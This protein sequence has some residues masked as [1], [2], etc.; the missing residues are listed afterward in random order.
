[1]KTNSFFMS[2]VRVSSSLKNMY[3]NFHFGDRAELVSW[4]GERI[5]FTESN[6][7]KLIVAALLLGLS[8][9]TWKAIIMY[10][11]MSVCSFALYFKYDLYDFRLTLASAIITLT[12][13]MYSIFCRLNRK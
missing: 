1:M 6:P 4:M 3:M 2:C 11:T 7:F 13:Y 8:N 10:L 9:F 5:E 12:L